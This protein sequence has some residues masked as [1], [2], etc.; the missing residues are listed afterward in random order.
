M[1]IYTVCTG[2]YSTPRWET[3]L[4]LLFLFPHRNP[5]QVTKNNS[6]FNLNPHHRR[7]RGRSLLLGDCWRDS[8]PAGTRGSSRT[9][10]WSITI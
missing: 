5:R 3:V 2:M 1:Y 8:S 7:G 9:C 4:S 6:E 10:R